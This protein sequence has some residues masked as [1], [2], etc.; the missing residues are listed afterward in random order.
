M[1]L[2]WSIVWLNKGLLA[3]GALMT[4]VLTV[5][6]MGLA[7]PLGIVLAFMRISK[8]RGLALPV[9]AF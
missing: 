9:L 7:V 2:D 1:T 3:E 5:L 6:T 4:I 8:W